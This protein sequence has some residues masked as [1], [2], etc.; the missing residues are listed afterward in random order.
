MKT[1]LISLINFI[2]TI[3]DPNMIKYI[4]QNSYSLIKPL[5]V[6]PSLF[7]KFVNIVINHFGNQLD[8]TVKLRA[9]LLIK[10]IASLCS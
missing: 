4:Y 10:S 3:H 1:F 8:I 6:F 2:K 7:K 9:F 5:L